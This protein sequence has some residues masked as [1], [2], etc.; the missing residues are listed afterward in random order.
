MGNLFY[1]ITS[2]K[3]MTKSKLERKHF[4]TF[5]WLDSI[6]DGGLGRNLDGGTEAEVMEGYCLLSVTRSAYFL[7]NTEPPDRGETTLVRWPSPLQSIK[8][9]C[10]ICLPPI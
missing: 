5:Y 8:K 6:M 2:R 4:I 10:H 1:F 3:T 9:C 7:Y